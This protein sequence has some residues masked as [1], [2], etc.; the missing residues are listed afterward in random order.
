M[1][2]LFLAIRMVMILG[3]AGVAA[4]QVDYPGPISPGPAKASRVG[5]GGVLSNGLISAAFGTKKG[6]PFF[7]GLKK[8]NVKIASGGGELFIL[9]TATGDIPA[10][11]MKAS[12]LRL[13][14]LP[15]DP[16]AL[17]LSQRFPGK[18]FAAQLTAPD[19]SLTVNWRAVLRDGS[20][21]LRQELSVTAEKDVRMEGIVG[22]QYLMETDRAGEAKISG[23]TRG[24][25]VVNDLAFAGLETPM[26][27]NSAGNQTVQGNAPQVAEPNMVQGYWSRKTTLRRGETWKLSSVL[28]VMEPG[29]HRRSFLRLQRVRTRGTL[30]PVLPL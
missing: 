22:M 20:H 25:L 18:A 29:Q 11:A 19:G 10:S 17:K 24:S 21:Y 2:L 5:S 8:G 23:N 26:G 30:P 9:K 16:K 7:A 6:S 4:A 27:I 12:P 14:D 28:G 15:A 1:K 3:L 13:V